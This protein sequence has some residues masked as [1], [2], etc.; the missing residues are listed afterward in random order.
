MG[1]FIERLRG[2]R[3][4]PQESCAQIEQN[5]KSETQ[6]KNEVSW[7]P[8]LAEV[9]SV[10][11]TS[12]SIPVNER[13]AMCV[14]AVF[15]CVSLIGGAIGGLPLPVYERNKDGRERA[16]HP[17]WD[18]L[19]VQPSARY[20]APVFW[21]YL[22]TSLLLQGDAFARIVRAGKYS[23]HIA[24]FELWHPSD[25]SVSAVADRLKYTLTN[26]ETRKVLVVDQDDMLHVPGIGFNGLR[27]LTP[28]SYALR[29]AVGIA[30]AANQHTESFFNNGARPD[31]VLKTEPEMTREQIQL[32]RDQWEEVHGGIGKKWKPA[33]LTGGLDIKE[34]TMS[35]DDAQLVATRQ[36]QIEDIAR[37]FGVPPFMIGLT[38]KTTS[39]GSGVEQMSIGFVKYTLMRHLKK[40]EQEIN[41]K[42][43][44]GTKFFVEFNTAGLER[45]DIKSRYE[46]Y[47][48]SLG[49]AG[50]P[51]WA[52]PNEIRR[53]ENMPPCDGYDE[54][55]R[56]INA[57]NSQASS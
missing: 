20:S 10:G 52:S 3:G 30:R 25:V 29:S 1:G 22:A 41:R 18:L 19:N 45:G 51:G 28:L 37:I 36:L 27:G 53:I 35:S 34:L 7:A 57:K 12:G 56:G 16:E 49:R 8:T 23:P 42:I 6:V 21:E 39:W 15:A 11:T 54:I 44:A 24:S 14:S 33:I 32:M 9:F 4:K 38:E 26:P 17:V 43:F 50:E 48:I 5:E 55:N 2:L 31:F 47:R 46:A 13:T 40:F